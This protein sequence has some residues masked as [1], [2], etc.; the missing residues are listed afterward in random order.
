M[1]EDERKHLKDLYNKRSTLLQKLKK[2]NKKE[3]IKTQQNSIDYSASKNI[4]TSQKM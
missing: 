3:K 2:V 1:N 4:S